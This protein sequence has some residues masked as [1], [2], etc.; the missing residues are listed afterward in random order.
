MLGW[1]SNWQYA[2]KV[3][4]RPWRGQ[5][6]IPR[7]T[8]LKTEPAGLRLVQEPVETIAGIRGKRFT[9]AGQNVRELNEALRSAS[10]TSFELQSTLTLGDAAEA[11]WRVLASDGTY[12]AVGYSQA[13]NQLYVDR[14]HSGITEFSKDF[15]VRTAAPL[16][17]SRSPLK[18]RILVDRSSV[19]VFAQ[20]G[21]VVMTN[22]V[23]P[24]T[25][26]KGVE[27][28]SEGPSPRRI[29]VEM[30]DLSATMR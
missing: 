23:Y 4:T 14:T 24:P 2:A 20:D 15:P 29:A 11:G 28:F 6:T 30:W 16:S 1:M 7:R 22:L 9:W 25:T 8:G 5:M 3:P 17:I 13:K 18:L 21:Q 26:A 27:F 12:T 10:S 19:E